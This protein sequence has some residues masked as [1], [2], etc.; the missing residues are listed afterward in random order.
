MDL[1]L[2]QDWRA[3][4]RMSSNKGEEA[5]ALLSGMVHSHRQPRPRKGKNPK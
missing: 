2:R 1:S 4:I 5:L 3:L